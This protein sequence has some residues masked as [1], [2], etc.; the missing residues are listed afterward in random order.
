MLGGS[1]LGIP[2]PLEQEDLG[3]RLKPLFT[4]YLGSRPSLG[5]V[6]QIDVFQFRCI[7]AGFDTLLQLWGHLSEVG[8]G[9][10]DSLLTLFYLLEFVETVADGG[11]LH[12]VETS[13]PFF[14]VT[15]DK[16]DGT[17]FFQE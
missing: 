10:D 11:Y 12:L 16:G 17:A 9:L 7:P 3:Q 8:D 1:T 6:W 14:P 2:F 4:S 5:L 13:R 15:R